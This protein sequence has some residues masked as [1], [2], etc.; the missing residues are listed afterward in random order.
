MLNHTNTLILGSRRALIAVSWILIGITFVSAGCSPKPSEPARRFRLH[1]KI[2]SI[3]VSTGS[4]DVDHDAIPGFMDAMTMPYAIP[5][6][7]V[8]SALNRG[9]EITADV[10]VV[11]GIPH[12]ENVVVVKHAPKPDPAS[13][14]DFHMP[15]P[16]DTVPDF[17]LVDQTGKLIHLRS[18]RGDALLLTFIYTRCRFADFCPKVSDDFA[19]IYA[20]LRKTSPA[21]SKVRLLS[22]SFDPHH[23]TPAVLRQ[24]AVTFR[25]IT[26]TDRPF[27]RWEF[28]AAPATELPKIAKFFGLYYTSQSGQIIHS[29]STSLISPDGK[30]VVWFHDNDWNAQDLLAQAVQTLKGS[31]LQNARSA[32]PSKIPGPLSSTSPGG[33]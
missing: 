32:N 18:Y 28:A 11:D 25:G 17:A 29:M 23:D 33:R 4:A 5:D 21:E 24:Y 14:S 27:D 20:A 16:G 7:K 12:L 8:L 2:V 9:D 10:V 3:D 22:V 30:I 6:K 1:G 15:Q 26:A 13:S 31:P 19:R